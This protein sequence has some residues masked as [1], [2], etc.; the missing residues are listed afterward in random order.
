MAGRREQLAREVRAR[1][2]QQKTL[3]WTPTPAWF[4]GGEVNIVLPDDGVDLAPITKAVYVAAIKEAVAARELTKDYLEPEVQEASWAR[5]VAWR[6]G[7]HGP[8]IDAAKQPA[9]APQPATPAVETYVQEGGTQRRSD[10]TTWQEPD[11][12]T[13]QQRLTRIANSVPVRY[14]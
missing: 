4:I 6:E 10:P 9:A 11:R 8:H 2:Q 13:E 14:F 7:D 3:E 1:L 12:E 5:F